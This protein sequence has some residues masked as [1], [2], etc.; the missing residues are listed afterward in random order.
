MKPRDYTAIIVCL[1]KGVHNVC[2][3]GL[4]FLSCASALAHFLC[5]ITQE[6]VWNT[7]EKLSIVL[8][9][10]GTQNRLREREM[11]SESIHKRRESV[12]FK[13]TYT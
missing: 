11:A 13:W 6:N 8:S 3:L 2:M 7:R 12:E 5:S 4:L 9:L 10:I 1:V